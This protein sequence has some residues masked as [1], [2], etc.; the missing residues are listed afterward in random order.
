MRAE[1]VE[2]VNQIKDHHTFLVADFSLSVTS[3]GK[4]KVCYILY[5]V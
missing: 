2:L 4:K 3:D 5:S 1:V